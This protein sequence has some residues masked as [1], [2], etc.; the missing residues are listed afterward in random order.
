MSYLTTILSLVFLV[1]GCTPAQVPVNFH[2]STIDYPGASE[3]T[4]YGIN[5]HGAFGHFS[6][7]VGT[8]TDNQGW[9]GFLLSGGHYLTLDDPIVGVSATFPT[10]INALGRI[11]GTYV[12]NQSSSR[13]F[14]YIAGTF[15]DLAECSYDGGNGVSV[16]NNQGDFVGNYLVPIPGQIEGRSVGYMYDST[17]HTFDWPKMATRVYGINNKN[18]MVGSYVDAQGQYH[19]AVFRTG[20]PM[21]QAL[22]VP[23]ADYTE[24]EAINDSGK[25]VG[26]C[27]IPGHPATR[28]G[29]L[30]DR[31]TG[32]FTLINVPGAFETFVYG[33]NNPDNLTAQYSIVGAYTDALGGKQHAFLATTQLIAHQ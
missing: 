22:D 33:I 4:A 10:G 8:Y 29:V 24:L 1:S 6:D 2:F 12:L 17:C 16:I 20:D 13:G 3:S 28:E 31:T 27:H 18:E 5:R 30:L 7:I 26:M 14:S 9:H 19:G 21:Y 15:S 23:G 25:V 32:A 11:V